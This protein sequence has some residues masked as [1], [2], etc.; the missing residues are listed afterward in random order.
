LSISADLC[1]REEKYS[2]I[3]SILSFFT[4]LTWPDSAPGGKMNSLLT[5]TKR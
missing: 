1:L 4:V 5:R 2:R 3:L